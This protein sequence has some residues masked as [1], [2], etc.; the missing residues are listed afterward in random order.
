MKS[1]T[2]WLLL[3]PVLM[4]LAGL[5]SQLRGDLPYHVST[6]SYILSILGWSFT[7]CAIFAL[8]RGSRWCQLFF[9]CIGVV[10]LVDTGYR[11]WVGPRS[12]AHIIFDIVIIWVALAFIRSFPLNRKMTKH[13]DA[14]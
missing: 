10:M 14:T 2:P 12:L 3:I 6:M 1:F 13:D 11:L 8:S 5:P 4:L 7:F 9:A